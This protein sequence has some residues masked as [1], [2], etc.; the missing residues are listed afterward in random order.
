MKDENIIEKKKTIMNIA[1][2][3]YMPFQWRME[4]CPLGIYNPL[5]LKMWHLLVSYPILNVI[6]QT[7]NCWTD[8]TEGHRLYLAQTSIFEDL[9]TSWKMTPQVAIFEK[10]NYI[11]DVIPINNRYT[12]PRNWNRTKVKW[13]PK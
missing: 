11:L 13:I 10:L 6:I 1:I 3:L 4:V 8:F 9:R 12:N 5:V 7:K 2:T